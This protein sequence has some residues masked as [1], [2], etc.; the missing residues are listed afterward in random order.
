ME[1]PVGTGHWAGDGT[2]QGRVVTA[3]VMLLVF[4]GPGAR[5]A[6]GHGGA[7]PGDASG[8]G[9]EHTLGS[10]SWGTGVALNTTFAVRW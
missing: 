10:G 7:G 8:L 5:V 3:R 9:Q 4:A 2:R 6:A 1:P